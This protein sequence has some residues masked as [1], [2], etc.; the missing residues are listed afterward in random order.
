MSIGF[1]SSNSATKD[2]THYWSEHIR[3]QHISGLSKSAY[4]REHNLANHK[5]MYWEKKLANSRVKLLPVKLLT[6]DVKRAETDQRQLEL[7]DV[8]HHL[9]IELYTNR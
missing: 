3:L 8:L 9:I 1:S 4:C 6:Q 5:F 7:P 2:E